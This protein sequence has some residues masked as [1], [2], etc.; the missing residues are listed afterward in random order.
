MSFTRVKKRRARRRVFIWLSGNICS[1]HWISSLGQNEIEKENF[2]DNIFGNVSS[3][4]TPAS[5]TCPALSLLKIRFI[6]VKTKRK[7]SHTRHKMQ[8]INWQM[9]CTEIGWSQW[10]RF[11]EFY[12]CWSLSLLPQLACSIHATWCIDLANLWRLI[13]FCDFAS[14]DDCSSLVQ[15]SNKIRYVASEW[16]R[17]SS[18]LV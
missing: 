2:E 14:L 6:Q 8:H 10:P 12:C 17:T 16:A 11:G 9:L 13:N 15:R 3:P 18:C 7:S 4:V 5:S 1:L